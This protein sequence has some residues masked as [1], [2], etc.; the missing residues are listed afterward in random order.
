MFGISYGDNDIVADP[1][2]VKDTIPNAGLY[3]DYHLQ[4][5]SPAI[6]AGD[7]KILDVDGSRSDIG[8]FGGPGGESYIYLD[9]PPKTP[10]NFIDSL[11][12]AN[13][14]LFLSWDLYRE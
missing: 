10:R 7:P 6:D 9:L 1:M 8:L 13:K 5:Y 14:I 2:F 3:F 12:S 4:A 11:D